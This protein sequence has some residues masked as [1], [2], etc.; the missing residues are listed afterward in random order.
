[1][2][3]KLPPLSDVICFLPYFSHC[4]NT[5]KGKT[6]DEV[7]FEQ[8]THP[9]RPFFKGIIAVTIFVFDHANHTREKMK[10]S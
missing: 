3:V 9:L 1:M 4:I 8:I 10:S 5:F 7:I 2:K 6:S